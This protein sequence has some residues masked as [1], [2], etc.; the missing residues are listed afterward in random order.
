MRSLISLSLFVL[1]ACVPALSGQD[2]LVGTL[3]GEF[4]VDNKG[5]AN[6][7]IPIQVP[8][9]I[10]GMQPSLSLNY[11]SNGGNG[12]MG[13][14]WSLSH[15]FPQKV[16][17]G[18][19]LLA[20]DGVVRGV[21]FSS[22]DKFFLDGKL[23]VGT[24]GSYGAPGSLYRSEVDA[25][26]TISASGG[27]D[28]NPDSFT[29]IDKNGITY[30]FGK[31]AGSSDAFQVGRFG[32][33]TD[34]WASSWLLKRVTDSS[35]NGIVFSYI[36]VGAGEHLL[37]QI[38]YIGTGA[39][40]LTRIR[41]V[42]ADRNDSSFR[43]VNTRLFEQSQR[44]ESVEVE[45]RDSLHD[46]FEI[47]A[48]YA[49]EYEYAHPHG[50][51]RLVAVAPEIRDTRGAFQTLP[52]T[53]FRW[54]DSALTLGQTQE[55]TL[56]NPP[57]RST[58]Q[59]VF[60]DFNGDGRTDYGIIIADALPRLD[61]YFRTDSGFGPARS[62]FTSPGS[63]PSGAMLVPADINGDGLRDLI[64]VN[65]GA[66]QIYAAVSQLLPDG[67]ARLVG[68]DGG[69]NP[70]LIISPGEIFETT[71]QAG[72]ESPGEKVRD[73]IHGA[74]LSRVTVSDF[75]GDGRDDVLLHGYD[76]NLTVFRSQ[77]NSFSS[78][79]VW[80]SGLHAPTT[81][82]LLG[83]TPDFFQRLDTRGSW[84]RNSYFAP[85][86]R[87]T[88]DLQPFPCELNGDGRTDYV[89]M[90]IR[91]AIDTNPNYYLYTTQKHIF[92]TVS[93][94]NG[95][96]GG[97]F[98]LNEPLI[99]HSP[100]DQEKV[101][102]VFVAGD[103]N[104]DGLTDFLRFSGHAS[105]N[106]DPHW[107]LYLSR[108]HATIPDFEEIGIGDWVGGE[109]TPPPMPKFATRPDGGFLRTYYS[110]LWTLSSGVVPDWTNHV[111]V[112]PFHFN[113]PLGNGL[114]SLIERTL[115]SNT[116]AIDVNEDG[117]TDHVWS[118]GDGSWWV[119]Y[120]RGRTFS[121]PEPLPLGAAD[122]LGNTECLG[123]APNYDYIKVVDLNSFVDLNGDGRNDWVVAVRTA[124]LQN[125]FF[126]GDG[127]ARFALATSAQPHLIT[128]FQS[129]LD[130]RVEVDYLAA[131]D[132][133]IYTSGA[134][135]QYPIREVMSPQAVVSAVRR[136]VGGEYH[137]SNENGIFDL[138]EDLV[139]VY[140]I[141]YQYSGRRTDLSGRGDLGFH[142]FVTLDHQ[143]GLFK[144]QFLEQSFP[145]TGL[146]KRE[147]TFR[148]LNWD[149]LDPRDFDLRII[150]WKDNAVVA[151]LVV[152]DS[153][154]PFGTIFPMITA[155]LE[156]RWED[157]TLPHYSY[158]P[159]NPQT[160]QFSDPETLFL[161]GLPATEAPHSSIRAQTW[162]DDQAES[163]EDNTVLPAAF[164]ANT[165][166]Q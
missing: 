127:W 75:D 40:A 159:A 155:S 147:Q 26:L 43:Y 38:E 52:P 158:V 135:V 106:Y 53:R 60:A 129:G 65:K 78:G 51:S 41:F 64:F 76:G 160:G 166:G 109:G 36:V 16:S 58:A 5:S 126:G 103:Y 28:G 116:F 146:T 117:M 79:E 145:M 107:R 130:S 13:V 63:L 30:V 50:N 14:G 101:E 34:S 48:R 19:S 123:V 35:G 164:E 153:D 94:P 2:T 11:N 33:Y 143:T 62:A 138:G 119:K 150:S 110:F 45:S 24:S 132:G 151:D 8:P 4:S 59:S 44:M 17:R 81:Q 85:N 152:D 61:M 133:R 31:H 163:G 148:A 161:Q 46:S 139:D 86:M 29:A 73:L 134:G 105:T 1:S 114:Y 88:F 140:H 67:T 7:S 22:D 162:F 131:K 6:Y 95:G 90:E 108:G 21:T 47:Q 122:L 39:A 66:Y 111:P 82:D 57:P 72:F 104:G 99:E 12:A 141:S 71:D 144:Y 112:L 128:G 20:R 42:H 74:I 100:I 10:N 77:G 125:M 102:C 156:H 32:G 89:W 87:H 84:G 56:P 121:D 96:F 113:D 25:F 70:T 142:S 157:G 15:G 165:F 118:P 54:S 23:L 37:D 154:E 83:Y 27:T 80:L 149:D 3:P 68:L 98:Y 92:A 137:D 49:L 69:V 115:S 120:S 9:G 97:A 18:R 93:Q 55:W 91:T 136:D 124:S